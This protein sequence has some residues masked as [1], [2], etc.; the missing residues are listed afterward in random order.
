MKWT[1]WDCSTN[2]V[3]CNL[4]SSISFLL[5]LGAAA[6]RSVKSALTHCLIIKGAAM[7]DQEN[8]EEAV[9]AAMTGRT[10]YWFFS[11]W[12]GVEGGK[13]PHCVYCCTKL[14]SKSSHFCLHVSTVKSGV[15]PPLFS[16]LL[17]HGESGELIHSVASLTDQWWRMHL[18]HTPTESLYLLLVGSSSFYPEVGVGGCISCSPTW[19]LGLH[20]C[21]IVIRSGFSETQRTLRA[22]HGCCSLLIY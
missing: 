22:E 1:E 14:H 5:P 8:V 9:G 12:G 10:R 13:S 17:G 18:R 15:S 7:S 21:I 20:K 2:Q 16:R 6:R 19:I 11:N 4:I 3:R